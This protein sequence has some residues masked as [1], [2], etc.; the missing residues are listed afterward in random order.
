MEPWTLCID[1]DQKS[2]NHAEDI[3]IYSE[4]LM[5]MNLTYGMAVN[6]MEV[7]TKI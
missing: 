4:D 1:I 6:I 2:E 3:K 5:N 7:K